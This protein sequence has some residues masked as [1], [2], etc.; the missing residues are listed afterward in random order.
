MRHSDNNNWSNS[1]FCMNMNLQAICKSILIPTLIIIGAVSS[2]VYLFL[3]ECYNG[4]S[5][6]DIIFWNDLQE[7]SVWE[8]TANKYMT[9]QGRYLGYFVNGLQYRIFGFF[10]STIPFTLIL[11][12]VEILLV[13]EI[14]KTLLNWSKWK[15]L[16]L[17]ILTFGLF[18]AC[19]PDIS[20]YYW[21]CAKQYPLKVIM[22]IW[23]LVKIYSYSTNKWYDWIGIFV[24]ACFV[25]CST[26]V[27]APMILV[28]LG[29]R[30]LKMWK[31]NAYDI[32]TLISK[33]KV[34][35]IVFIV[36]SI[37][38]F[39]MVFSPST[40]IRMEVHAE[41]ASLS[42]IEFVKEIYNSSFQ[43][44][45]MIF[46]KLHYYVA[47]FC[48]I[49]MILCSTT[50]IKKEMT[51]SQLIKRTITNIF[52]AVGLFL[53]SMVLCE[54]A[55]GQPFIARA[56]SQLPAA[57]YLLLFLFARDLCQTK[58]S[59]QVLNTNL[60]GGFTIAALI[61]ISTNNVYATC[62]A[63]SEL[64]VYKESEQA[65]I[66]MLNQ[67]QSQG[68]TETII[69]E[70]LD[71][72]DYHSIMDDLWRCVMPSYSK[73]A[74]LKSNE[75]SNDLNQCYNVAFRKYY[76]LDFDVISDLVYEGV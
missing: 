46:F 66:K 14:Y 74:L 8:W 57:I 36:A 45:K 27:F 73:I 6:D 3:P 53:L 48:L 13:G 39:A 49:L 4:L 63:Y 44:A 19:L 2:I 40:F 55:C 28:L 69:L 18:I 12:F 62:H 42:V 23:L 51:L 1:V 16:A 58:F 38:F 37:N 68:N 34:L 72:A 47:Y 15:I 64:E 31:K 5:L 9:W 52:I 32:P 67:L 76:K 33:E 22:A 70:S 41:A 25:G 10:G 56:F 61:F 29:V 26:E 54:W 35:C 50:T 11:Y 75:V 30:V 59:R 20:S 24:C 43:I 60:L 21:M 71:V 7:M 17:S 65:R